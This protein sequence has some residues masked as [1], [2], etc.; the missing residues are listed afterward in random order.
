[1]S[2]LRPNVL[3]FEKARIYSVIAFGDHKKE[4]VTDLL[5]VIDKFTKERNL[6]VG[7]KS[8]VAMEMVLSIASLFEK[9]E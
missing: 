4:N 7:E 6:S 5:E 1:M 2:N 3:D 9:D 8:L